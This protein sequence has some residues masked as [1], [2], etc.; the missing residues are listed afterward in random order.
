[1]K[2]ICATSLA[3]RREIRPLVREMD[4]HAKFPNAVKTLLSLDMT[5]DLKRTV[6][7]DNPTRLY[8]LGA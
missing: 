6:L 8:N 2:R 4:E 7:W 5:D 1:M 3:A